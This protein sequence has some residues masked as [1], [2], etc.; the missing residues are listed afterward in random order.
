M[1]GFQGVSNPILSIV[2]T[3]RQ[4]LKQCLDYY[5]HSK[6]TVGTQRILNTQKWHQ[7]WKTVFTLKMSDGIDS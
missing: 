7:L 3:S 4:C 1:L 2:D 5:E 6:H